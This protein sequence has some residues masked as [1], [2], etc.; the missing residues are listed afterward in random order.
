M[1]AGSGNAN[2]K[3]EAELRAITEQELTEVGDCWVRI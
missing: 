2:R 3:Q 1:A